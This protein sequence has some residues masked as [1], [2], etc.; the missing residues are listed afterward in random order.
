MLS[1]G[2][3]G[4]LAV[5]KYKIW[6]KRKC[7][8]FHHSWHCRWARQRQSETLWKK[9]GDQGKIWLHGRTNYTGGHVRQGRLNGVFL[10]LTATLGSNRVDGIVAIDDVWFDD[11]PCPDKGIP[12][13]QGAHFAYISHISH[14]SSHIF[15]TSSHIS[16]VF[17][18]KRRKLPYSSHIFP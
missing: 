7:V 18:E 12:S 10:T 1:G 11:V 16:H 4:Q 15:M 3:V 9:Q 13:C 14:N 5:E 8:R 6:M 2:N 17:S